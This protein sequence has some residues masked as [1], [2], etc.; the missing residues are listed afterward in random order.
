MRANFPTNSLGLCHDRP[1]LAGLPK[2][3]R[4]G[5]VTLVVLRRF[6]RSLSAVRTLLLASSEDL[7]LDTCG[8]IHVTWA[9]H[10]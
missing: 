3:V 2:Y 7:L 9:A 8:D 10:H 6:G 5:D 1:G 4:A